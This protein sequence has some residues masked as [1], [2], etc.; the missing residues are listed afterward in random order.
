MISRR[1][2][3]KV[4]GSTSFAA[5]APLAFAQGGGYP[6]RSI[7]LVCPWSPGGVVDVLAR[8]LAQHIG[9]ELGQTVV[10]DNKAG[11][12]GMIGS[13]EVARAPADGYTLL[14]NSSSL[15]QA[16]LI[17]KQ[18]QYD[19]L[20]DFTAI[21]SFGRTVMP[22]VVPASSPANTLTEFVNYARGKKLAYGTYGAGTTS[23]AFQQLLSDHHK[24]DMVHVPY[25][26]EAPMLNDL[27]G[28]QVPCAMGTMNTLA[29][30]IKAGAI[31][32]LALLSPERIEE[33]PN[34]PTFADL[35]YPA[36]FNWGG[37]F[38]GF[39]GPANMPTDVTARLADGFRKAL[40]K[41]SLQ[42]IMKQAYVTGRPSYL[43]D[44]TA[45]VVTTH[46]AWA[47]LVNQL[48]LAA[49]S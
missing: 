38:I 14:F 22:F 47:K 43:R 46:E 36:D 23:H 9:P 30:Q 24:L 48:N 33:F 31:K 21:G 26:G 2:L 7:R 32:A 37:G 41:P 6:V 4:A 20:K 5:A 3:L 16:P 15:V 45:E 29:P 34:V 10:V 42:Q 35:R 18:R 1:D 13:A 27:L 19:A 12:G 17:A 44:T 8:A 49:T 40:A 28:G 11:A 39:F 25:K